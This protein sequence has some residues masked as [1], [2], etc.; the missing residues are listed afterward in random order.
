VNAISVKKQYKMVFFLNAN[1]KLKAGDV[2]EV[3]TPEGKFTFSLADRQ[4]KMQPCIWKRNHSCF[5]NSKV[6]FE[7]RT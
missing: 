5:V 4:K 3:G 2:L 6:G 7:K 1:S